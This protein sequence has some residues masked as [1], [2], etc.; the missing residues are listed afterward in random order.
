MAEINSMLQLPAFLQ[1]VEN[2]MKEMEET[3]LKLTMMF[4]KMPTLNDF[5]INLLMI[6]I[7]P[8]L[9]EEMI[10]RGVLQKSLIQMTRS[11]HAGIFLSAFIFSFIH[12][13]FYGFLPRMALGIFFGYLFLWSQTLWLTVIAHLINNAG[14][15][16]FYY[17]AD[18]EVIDKK[19]E[20][21]GTPGN[22]LPLALISA[23]VLGF[24]IF[25][26][27]KLNLF[28]RGLS[29]ETNDLN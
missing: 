10:F 23:I 12:L 24:L 16:I 15:V 1:G 11:P 17:L 27:Y 28:N 4:L 19:I 22:L 18:N 9:G 3:A 21:I 13:Q 7:L 20:T 5:L 14:A 25:Q 2:W 6:G 29:K 8:A 26:I